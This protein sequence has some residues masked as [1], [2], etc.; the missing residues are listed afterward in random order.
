MRCSISTLITGSFQKT[1][2]STNFA[3]NMRGV[4]YAVSSYLHFI[5]EEQS[6][7]MVDAGDA[8]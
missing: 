1:D 2:E 3:S 8:S 7:F 4:C 5:E 6:D